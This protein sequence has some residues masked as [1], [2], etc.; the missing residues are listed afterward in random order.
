[1]SDD[2][3]ECHNPGT[4]TQGS[5]LVKQVQSGQSTSAH[6]TLSKIGNIFNTTADTDGAT[7]GRLCLSDDQVAQYEACG[8]SHPPPPKQELPHYYTV[9]NPSDFGYSVPKGPPVPA[10]NIYDTPT[11]QEDDYAYTYVQI[12][13]T[14]ESSQETKEEDTIDNPCEEVLQ[15]VENGMYEV[16]PQLAFVVQTEKRRQMVNEG[17]Y[18]LPPARVVDEDGDAVEKEV[19]GTG[20]GQR[21]NPYMS[22]DSTQLAENTYSTIM[23]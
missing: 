9:T 16:D 19:Q 7:E 5:Y 18:Q 17:H 8:Y 20:S 23:K 11:Q 10:T 1:M 2:Y 6:P 14:K 15:L 3:Y 21:H 4:L 13:G 12:P 22:L